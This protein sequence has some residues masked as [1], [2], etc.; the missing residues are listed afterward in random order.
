MGGQ[1]QGGPHGSVPPRA[2]GDR[3]GASIGFRS[4]ARPAAE[5]KTLRKGSCIS[6]ELNTKTPIPE[7]GGEPLFVMMEDDA[8]LHDDGWHFFQP[9]QEQWFLIG[10]R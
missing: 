1:G 4:A 3:L 10:P 7:W 5:G 8:W 2:K 6:I 9:R